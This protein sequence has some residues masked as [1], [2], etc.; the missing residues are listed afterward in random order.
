MLK[1]ISDETIAR[2]ASVVSDVLEN[3]ESNNVINASQKRALLQ[4]IA[5]RLW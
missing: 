1:R 4:D 5:G 2:A 3:A